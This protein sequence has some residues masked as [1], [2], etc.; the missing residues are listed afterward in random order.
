M[1]RCIAT[2]EKRIDPS[3][4]IR[5]NRNS[6]CSFSI[7]FVAHHSR[8]IAIMQFWYDSCLMLPTVLSKTTTHTRYQVNDKITIFFVFMNFIHF[9]CCCFT[10]KSSFPRAI[11]HNIVPAWL[12]AIDR[13]SEKEKVR[14]GWI[15]ISVRTMDLHLRITHFSCNSM[16][17][18]PTA[19]RLR[20]SD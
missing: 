18:R 19:A 15:E 10:S 1:V 14:T 4:P 11:E 2:I 13:K 6:W 7:N 12:S 3:A 17:S 9:Y 16:F 20:A 8:T 5:V